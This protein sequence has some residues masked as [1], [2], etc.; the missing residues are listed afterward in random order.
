MMD[1]QLLEDSIHQV[2]DVTGRLPVLVKELSRRHIPVADNDQR[3]LLI[4]AIGKHGPC[5]LITEQGED[6]QHGAQVVSV[7]SSHASIAVLRFSTMVALHGISIQMVVPLPGA[8]LTL[9]AP[10]I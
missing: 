10:F 9:M 7:V 6:E 5:P 8:E 2:D 3:V 4:V 1:A